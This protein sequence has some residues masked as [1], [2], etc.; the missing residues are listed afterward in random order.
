MHRFYITKGQI[1]GSEVHF[2]PGQARQMSRVLR[3]AMGERVLTFNGSGQE[4]EVE[5]VRISPRQVVGRILA[6]RS[7]AQQSPLQITLLQGLLKGSKMDYLIQ[8]AAELGVA[9]ITVLSLRRT[10]AEGL[11]KLNRWRRIAIEASEQSGC[12]TI[13]AV[14]GPYPL[15]AYLARGEGGCSLLLWEGEKGKTLSE[16][17]DREPPSPRVRILVGPE[18]GLEEEEVRLLTRRGFIPL[19]LGPRTLRAETA[20]IAAITILQHRWGDLC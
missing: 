6:A 16:F 10:V 17:F 9:E 13:P 1:A 7:A 3:I 18:G 11:G 14:T 8:K 5:I 19:S 20:A 12:L 2:A 15:A 4:W